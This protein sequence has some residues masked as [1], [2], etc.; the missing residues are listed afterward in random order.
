MPHKSGPPRWVVSTFFRDPARPVEW[1]SLVWFV[2]WGWY[3]LIAPEVLVRD[4]YTAFDAFPAFVWSLIMFVLAAV[5]LR[6]ILSKSDS[7]RLRFI[8]MAS[9][10]GL[11]AVV[12]INFF[13]A[14]TP[15]TGVVVYPAFA[16]FTG[17]T[18]MYIEW[19]N[20]KS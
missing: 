17:L 13:A 1:L 16:F 12:S 3:L 14:G 18:G 7:T 2:G 19:M 8:A 10:S 6:A 9:A 5:Q 15:T 20:S 11:W 4:T